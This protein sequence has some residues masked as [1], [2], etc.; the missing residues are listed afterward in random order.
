MLSAYLHRTLLCGAYTH[1]YGCI[2]FMVT[3]MDVC[4]VI[5]NDK[6]IEMHRISWKIVSTYR[7]LLLEKNRFYNYWLS[8]EQWSHIPRNEI[9]NLRWRLAS[10]LLITCKYAMLRRSIIKID[11]WN[12]CIAKR[13]MAVVVRLRSNIDFNGG[14]SFLHSDMWIIWCVKFFVFCYQRCY[15]R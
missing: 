5:R 9:K 15:V 10:S 3:R 14:F 6:G 12:K 4:V 8:R 11:I 7:V 13:Q 2:A 1:I